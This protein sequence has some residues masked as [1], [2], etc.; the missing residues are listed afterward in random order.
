MKLRRVMKHVT[1]R[2]WFAV[3]LDFIVVIMEDG[4]CESNTTGKQAD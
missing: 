2:N 4:A 3:A 1:D